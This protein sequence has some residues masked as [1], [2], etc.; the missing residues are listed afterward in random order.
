[1]CCEDLKIGRKTQCRTKAVVVPVTG[2][3]LVQ[4]DSRR[5]GVLIGSS[6]LAAIYIGTE[7]MS[8]NDQGILLQASAAPL[9]LL[10]S[11]MG[12]IVRGPIFAWPD[13]VQVTINFVETLDVTNVCENQ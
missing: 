5:I 6:D 9:L 7:K 3:E 11:E 2:V 13:G 8:A 4:K 12:D 10:I 1:M